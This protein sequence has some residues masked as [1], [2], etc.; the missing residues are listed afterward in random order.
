VLQSS[1]TTQ[2]MRGANK[3][4]VGYLVDGVNVTDPMFAVGMA[5]TAYTTCATPTT[6]V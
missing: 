6:A 5:S 1:V 4:G 3:V 2:A